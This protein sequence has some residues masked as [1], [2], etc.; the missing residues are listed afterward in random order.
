METKRYWLDNNANLIEV[1]SHDYY[2]SKMLR[3]ELTVDEY[4]KLTDTCYPYE[5][6]HKRGWIRITAKMNNVQIVGDCINPA[7]IMK[8]TLDPE[9]NTK[10]IRAAK[11]LC[12]DYNYDFI[13][14]INWRVQC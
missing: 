11:K 3:E 13:D 14:A 5:I 9:M 10:Q 2:A 7:K 6:L 4:Y 8:N 1:S 12:K